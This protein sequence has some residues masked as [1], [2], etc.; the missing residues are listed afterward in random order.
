MTWPDG[1][2]GGLR[3]DGRARDLLTP[4]DGAARVLATATLS[5]R[6]RP[7][8]IVSSIGVTPAG[9]AVDR[10]VGSGPGRGFRRAIADA[11]AGADA[12]SLGHF[13]AEDLTTANLLSTFA[14]SRIPEQRAYFFEESRR[15]ATLVADVCSGYRDGGIALEL[16]RKGADVSQSVAVTGGLDGG[17]DPLAWHEFSPPDG[18]AMCR[19]RRLDVWRDDDVYRVD[20]MFRD[21]S[22]DAD[23]REAIVHEYGLVATVDTE[24]RTL[25]SLQA[26]PRVLPYPECPLAADEIGRCTGMTVTALRSTVLEELRG[27]ESCTHLNDMLRALAELPSALDFLESLH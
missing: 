24:R 9:P 1:H 13:L 26:D 21:N 27:I 23:G 4:H 22:W 18:V 3:I 15:P 2:T 10:I 16:R 19:R 8:G 11:Y 7:D 25:A 5:V 20:A 17:G 6:Q 12:H 14:W